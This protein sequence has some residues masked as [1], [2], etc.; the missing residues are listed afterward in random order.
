MFGNYLVTALRNIARHRLYSLINIAGLAVGLVCAVFIILF[1][2]DEISYDKWIPASEN[3]YRIEHTLVVP[4]QAPMPSA[5]SPYPVAV[6]MQQQIPEVTGVTHLTGQRLTAL[7]GNRLFLDQFYVVDPNFFQIIKLPLV[8]GSP[9][10]VFSQADSVVLSQA[11]A[12]KYFG[13]AEPLGKT[14]ILSENRCDDLGENCQV[15]QYDLKVTGVMRDIPHNSHLLIDAL[16]PTTSNADPLSQKEKKAWFNSHGYSY[17]RLA[18]GAD[19]ATV[20]AKLKPIIDRSADPRLLSALHV[21]ASAIQQIRLVPFRDLHLT[22]DRDGG[23]KP[24]GSWATIYGFAII[25]I[26][27]QL[28][29]CFNFTNLAT[30]RATMRAREVSLRK[31]MGATRIQLVVQ[32]LGES[33]LMS[34][35]ALLVALAV[36][37]VLL[38][39][40]DQFLGRPIGFHYLSDWAVLLSVIGIALVSGLLGGAYPAFVLSGFRPA[41]ILRANQAKQGGSGLLRTTLV[42]L[43]FAVSIGLGIAALVIF[44]QI[45]FAR[46]LDLGFRKDNIVVIAARSMSPQTRDSFERTLRNQPGVLGVTASNYVPLDGNDSNWDVHVSGDTWRPV[47]RIVQ[48]DPDFPK[49]YGVKLVAGRFLD[50]NRGSDAT[51]MPLTFSYSGPGF[52]VLINQ[53]AM[54]EFGFTPQNAV[55]R[56]IFLHNTEVTIVGVLADFK[57]Q[58]TASPVVPTVYFNDVVADNVISVR[59]GSANTADMLA[60]IDRLWRR[61]APT[62]AIQRH[63]MSDDFDKQFLNDDRQGAIFDLFVAIAIFIAC[64]GLFGLAAFTAGRRTKEIGV[65][66]VFGARTRDVIFLLL[67]QFSIPVL[68]ANAIAWPLAWYYLHNW[69]ESYAY[70]IALSPFY[71]LIAGAAALL[72]AWA[73]IFTHAR[74]V[75]SANPIH[76]L[77]YE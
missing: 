40:F 35:F 63:L 72:I 51:P 34:L 75:A 29:A 66:K 32:F 36:V 61:F 50:R 10:A 47:M 23:M 49:L 27:I 22:T 58:G 37:E 44:A 12:R 45:S 3:L 60:M 20:L 52:N 7:I 38:P 14:I 42:V 2:R 13:D 59:L 31:V 71:F 25:G 53:S 43:Q 46:N 5:N 57:W 65:R 64:L 18:P 11:R 62:I 55:G 17:A 41:T 39:S 48:I 67:W 15:K 76:A 73:T 19:P 6:A 70:R 30:A 21:P 26:L 8:E 28:V 24:P 74:R 33:L 77:R 4:G 54:K 69:L 68:V 56:R 16:F 1:I 9:A